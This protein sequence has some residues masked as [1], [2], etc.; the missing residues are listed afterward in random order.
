[1]IGAA[2]TAIP[3]VLLEIT[4]MLLRR[5]CNPWNSFWIEGGVVFVHKYE[6]LLSNTSIN[7]GAESLMS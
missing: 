4:C 5:Y 3:H 7:L 2:Q 6:Q 1:M